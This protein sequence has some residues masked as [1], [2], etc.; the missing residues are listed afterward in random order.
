MPHS[1]FLLAGV[2]EQAEHAIVFFAERMSAL[3]R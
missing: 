1:F 3:L 2:L